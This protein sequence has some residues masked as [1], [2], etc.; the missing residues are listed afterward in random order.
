MRKLNASEKAISVM[1]YLLLW[2]ARGNCFSEDGKGTFIDVF[3]KEELG[4][5]LSFGVSKS[6]KVNDEY[7]NEIAKWFITECVEGQLLHTS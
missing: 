6:L 1:T 2:L 4:E 7:V 5:W 3:I